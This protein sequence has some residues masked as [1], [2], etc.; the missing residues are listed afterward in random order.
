MILGKNGRDLVSDASGPKQD[1]LLP[2][3]H[4]YPSG[5]LEQA[6]L[7]SISLDVATDLRHPVL[8]VVPSLE[9]RNAVLEVTTVPE[10]AIAEDRYTVPRED[11]VWT[12][13]QP[14]HVQPVPKAATPE[15]P[16]KDDLA[17]R[18]G[19]P[20]RAARCGGRAC[21]GWA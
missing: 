8:G 9:L 15:L 3:A 12:P 7:L 17:A 10:V 14:R 18:V 5:G 1:I 2:D 4:D 11:D 21:G 19:L 16:T 6:R 20:A 13:R